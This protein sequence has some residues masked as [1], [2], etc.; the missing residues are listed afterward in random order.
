VSSPSERNEV[1]DKKQSREK[2]HVIQPF[3]NNTS[4]CVDQRRHIE[5]HY[6]GRI[7]SQ[8]KIENGSCIQDIPD[9]IP[10]RIL[11]SKC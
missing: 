4:T 11:K 10:Y 1:R 3:C 6:E 7:D 5:A 8:G 9:T 2:Y